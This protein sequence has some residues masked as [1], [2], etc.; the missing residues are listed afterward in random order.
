MHFLL[1]LWPIL[2]PKICNIYSTDQS[3]NRIMESIFLYFSASQRPLILSH[4]FICTKY[5]PNLQRSSTILQCCLSVL[6]N[7]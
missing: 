3:I 6:T 4:K 5:A 7:H 2:A 1:E